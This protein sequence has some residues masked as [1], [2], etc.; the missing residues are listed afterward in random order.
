MII[1]EKIA[2]KLPAERERMKNLITNHEDVKICDVTV[3][4]V[5]RGIRDVQI[6]VTDISYVDPY[7]GVLLRNYT[8][9]ETI[10][11]LPK[12]PNSEYPLLGGLFY[13][14]MVGDM[15]TEAEAWEVE[16]EWKKRAALPPHVFDLIRTMPA[17]SHPMTLFIQGILALQNEAIFPAIYNTG[18]PK[19]DFWLYYL[20]D[21]LNLTAKLPALAAFIYNYRYND[22]KFIQPKP[23]LDW[24]ANFAHMIGHKE[25]AIYQDLCRL[26][27][28]IHA[29]HEGG[30]VSAH[31]AHL[32]SSALADI[33][34]SASA[35]MAGLA[36]PLHG[37]ANQECL[38]WL[39]DVYK[40]FEVFP[41]KL[42]LEQYLRKLLNEGT[43]IP[44]YGHAVLRTT[45]PRFTVQKDFADKYI[46]D[47]EMI[48]L[49]EMVY[50][51]LPPILSESGKVK[52]PYP[53]VDAINGALQH[54]F[55]VKQ[56]DFYTVL[57]GVSRILG[58]SSHAVWSRALNKPIE[59]PKSLTTDALEAI[60]NQNNL[61]E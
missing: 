35:C 20:D 44:G 32:V 56:F 41:T 37:L 29:D 16:N 4:Q 60:I 57:F 48:K 59:R 1:H 19:S 13:L 11:K 28:T 49:V 25:D 46:K 8:I 9:Q 33:Y 31:A 47:D 30:N 14:L 17:E 23:D 55:G 21:C 3:G 42:E 38:K 54:H 24:A 18:I 12:A 36:G 39:L 40:Q 22:G 53:N 15:P 7:K 51:I 58:I 26:F 27:F 50:E 5:Y 34:L 10:K 6:Q 61:Q 45:D 43:I 2:D 52:N